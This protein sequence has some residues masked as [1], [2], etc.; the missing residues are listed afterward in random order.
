MT[1]NELI[2]GNL[3]WGDE[4]FV[5]PNLFS[6]LNEKLKLNSLVVDLESSIFLP[7]ERFYISHKH[8]LNPQNIVVTQSNK[9]VTFQN[10]NVYQIE[11]TH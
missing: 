8:I 6:Y 10:S 2:T 9:K 1:K 11:L 7:Y 3:G 5:L 4:F